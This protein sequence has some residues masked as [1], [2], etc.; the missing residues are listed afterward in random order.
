M[1]LVTHSR[2][3]RPDVGRR[4]PAQIQHCL[5]AAK[6]CCSDDMT[7]LKW[8]RVWVDHESVAAVAKLYFAEAVR[9]S[10]MVDKNV[11]RLDICRSIRNGVRFRWRDL[12]NT[13]VDITTTV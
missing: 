9:C 8:A 10:A 5:G 7:F 12:H 6:Y 1:A 3:K 13:G 2:S 11:V 4:L